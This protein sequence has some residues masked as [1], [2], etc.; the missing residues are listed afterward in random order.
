MCGACIVMCQVN[1]VAIY[2]GIFE[3]VQTQQLASQ[4]LLLI[5]ASA[6]A[7]C[8]AAYV[9]NEKSAFS[10]DLLTEHCRTL[11][12]LVLFG[13]GFTPVVRCCWKQVFSELKRPFRTLTT[14]ISTDTI[15]STSMFLFAVSF[16]FHDYGM[17]APV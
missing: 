14:S 8:F 3:L 2:I 15:Y 10:L 17:P 16:V 4:T 5:V 11:L 7:F 6:V 9:R 12:T 1:M 13:Y